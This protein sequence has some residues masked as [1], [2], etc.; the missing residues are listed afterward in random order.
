MLKVGSVLQAVRTR[1][2][3]TQE[4]MAFRLHM[5]Q[6]DVSKIEKDRKTLDFHII[7]KW[8]DIT[9]AREVIVAFIYG[10]DGIKI[11]Q[12]ILELIS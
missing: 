7:L 2:G 12:N 10:M 1:A 9:N 4:E 5:N 11:M 6:S 8:A 3:L